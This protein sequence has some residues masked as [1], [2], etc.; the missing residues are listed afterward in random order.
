MVPLV[1]GTVR[2]WLDSLVGLTAAAGWPT[3]SDDWP[4]LAWPAWPFLPIPPALLTVVSLPHSAPPG[5]PPQ[6]KRIGRG[7]GSGRGGTSG[8]GH[9]GQGARSGNGKPAL[10]FAGGQTPIT[11]AYPK[12]GFTNTGRQ[13]MT[14]LNLDRLQ[15]WIDLGRIDPSRPIGMRELFE[16]RCVH[17]VGEGVKV[18]ADV[19]EWYRC[20]GWTMRVDADSCL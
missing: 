13:T 15:H 12:R 1:L 2:S 3:F 5:F 8:R 17:G 6:R 10:H 20:N 11:R 16:S 9:K 18:L 4:G 19:S 14:P 7:I